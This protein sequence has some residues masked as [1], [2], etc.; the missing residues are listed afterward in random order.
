M[1][2]LKPRGLIPCPMLYSYKEVV[3]GLDSEGLAAELESLAPCTSWVGGWGACAWKGGK[4][5]E[6][7]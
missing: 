6:Y 3:L 1:R 7:F 5:W 2:K 4:E